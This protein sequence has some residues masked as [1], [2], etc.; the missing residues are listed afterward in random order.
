MAKLVKLISDTKS[1]STKITL[2]TEGRI[3]P[4]NE[5]IYAIVDSINDSINQGKQISFQYFQYDLKNKKK[6][7]NNELDPIC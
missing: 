3:K 6:P 1:Q 4:V 5:K 2:C 7:K